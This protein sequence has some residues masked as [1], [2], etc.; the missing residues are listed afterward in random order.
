MG[1]TAIG[2]GGRLMVVVVGVDC[3][4]RRVF[5]DRFGGSGGGGRFVLVASPFVEM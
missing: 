4:V 5:S 2:G 3:M 1:L